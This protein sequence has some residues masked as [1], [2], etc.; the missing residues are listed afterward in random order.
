MQLCVRLGSGQPRLLELCQAGALQC[1]GRAFTLASH[2][3]CTW[4][5]QTSESCE[6]CRPG[7]VCQGQACEGGSLHLLAVRDHLFSAFRHVTPASFFLLALESTGQ[8]VCQSVSECPADSAPLCVGAGAAGGQ[9]T[10]SQCEF[11]ARRCAGEQ[12]QA[13]SIQACPQ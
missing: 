3:D 5:A 10:M 2:Q 13:I 7:T 4:P 9:S 8:C 1:M 12:L 6:D 11:G